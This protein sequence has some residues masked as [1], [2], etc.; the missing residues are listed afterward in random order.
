MIKPIS[1]E[2]ILP[3]W[4]NYLWPNRISEI[5]A[6]SAMTYLGGYDWYN[7]STVPTFFGYY[8]DGKLVGVNSGHKTL[9]NSYRARGLYVS[10]EMRGKGIGTL[11]LIAT[12]HQASN[13]GCDFCWSY[14]RYT[15]WNTYK[16]A[17]FELTSDWE[18][19]ETSDRNAY[20]YIK[21]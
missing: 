19:S 5:T 13:E 16:N 4:K 3:I 18:K 15:S 9:T 14:P 11:L 7:M 1:F 10:P 17:G 12:I 2:E 21:V 6:N 20:C 8:V